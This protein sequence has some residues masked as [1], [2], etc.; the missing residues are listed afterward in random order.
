MLHTHDHLISASLSA[1]LSPVSPNHSWTRQGWQKMD[2]VLQVKPH[3]CMVDDNHYPSS[4]SHNI[5]NTGLPRCFSYSD[6]LVFLG[7]AQRS[8]HQH[9]SSFS[10][11]H[12]ITS[13]YIQMHGIVPPPLYVLAPSPASQGFYWLS[14]RVSEGSSA[15]KLC[16]SAYESPFLI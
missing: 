7:H 6:G 12:T 9:T 8:I 14:P 16:Y 11:G 4:A 13:Q 15:L 1:G 3:R 10:A 5:P 2:T